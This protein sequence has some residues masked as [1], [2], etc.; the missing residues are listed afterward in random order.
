MDAQDQLQLEKLE[1]RRLSKTL[2]E[3]TMDVERKTQLLKRHKEEYHNMN[4][5][6]GSLCSKL[7]RAMKVGA[8]CSILSL[9]PVCLSPGTD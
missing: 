4:K 2:S 5:S 3:V 6:M 1:S 7:E 9:S 8:H